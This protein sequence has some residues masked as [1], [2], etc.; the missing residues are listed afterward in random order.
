MNEYLAFWMNYLNFS[1]RTTVR[2]YWMAFLFNVIA[3]LILSLIGRLLRTNLPTYLFSL[4]TLL[5]GIAIAV[6]RLRDAGRHW[7]WIFIGLI[8]LVGPIWLIVLLCKP[9]VS[10]SDV[11]VV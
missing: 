9:S 2:G 4:A 11:P 7:T 1:D 6:R 3:N 5:P 8:P 10:Y